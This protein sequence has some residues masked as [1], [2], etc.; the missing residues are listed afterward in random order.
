MRSDSRSS[1]G[2]SPKI[3]EISA[4]KSSIKETFMWIQLIFCIWS[5]L[6]DTK[7]KI[8]ASEGD[9]KWICEFLVGMWTV[10]I[11]LKVATFYK[12]IFIFLFPVWLDCNLSSTDR[13]PLSFKPFSIPC[14]SCF[15][16][17][18]FLNLFSCTVSVLD[19]ATW[20]AFGDGHFLEELT[21][22]T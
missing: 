19:A 21:G 15:F 10:W 9:E 12:K 6:A 3:T 1:I 14:L 16:F 8:L 7:R 20:N 17:L 22:L 4:D 5:I 11:F 13:P 2:R 18:F